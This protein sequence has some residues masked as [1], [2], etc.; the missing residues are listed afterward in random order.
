MSMMKTRIALTCTSLA[1]LGTVSLG[2][3]SAEAQTVSGGIYY[4]PAPVYVEPQPAYVYPPAY[5]YPAPAYYYP[6]APT[7]YYPPPPPVYYA[8][9]AYVV[10]GIS[11]TFDFGGGGGH[12]WRRH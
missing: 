3:L 11:A 4:G 12:H 6:P 8:Q 2:A 5:Y 9:P 1:L 10:P 7:Y